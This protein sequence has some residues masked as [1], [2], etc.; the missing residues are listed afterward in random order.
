MKG[1]DL[2]NAL[3]K[4]LKLYRHHREF[5]QADLAERANISITFLSDIERGNK[6]PYPDTLVNLAGALDVPVST[7]FWMETDIAGDSKAG[8]LQFSRDVRKHVNDA[9]ETLF[10]VYQLG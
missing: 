9:L 8:M 10:K 7:L 4:N 2:R 1:D 3:G 5:S 6:W